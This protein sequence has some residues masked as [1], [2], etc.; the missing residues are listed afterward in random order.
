[1][2]RGE[3]DK[4]DFQ[5]GERCSYAYKLYT[6]C[7]ERRRTPIQLSRRIVEASTSEIF[8]KHKEMKQES[9]R[10]CGRMRT[11]PYSRIIDEVGGKRT[12]GGQR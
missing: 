11:V 10:T 3:L 7:I 6:N 1:M 4:V 9:R 8:P 2:R 12:G 5:T